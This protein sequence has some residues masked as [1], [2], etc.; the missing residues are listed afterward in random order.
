MALFVTPCLNTTPW[1]TSLPDMISLLYL[2]WKPSCLI[3]LWFTSIVQ[4]PQIE[5]TLVK[6]TS[7]KSVLLTQ[8]QSCGRGQLPVRETRRWNAFICSDPH[9]RIWDSHRL[10][11]SKTDVY[12]RAVIQP[13]LL[14][15][16]PSFM[17]AVRRSKGRPRQALDCP[18]SDWM[19]LTATSVVKEPSF[20]LKNQI[21]WQH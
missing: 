3:S 4:R 14:V 17:R 12:A 2:W 15:S 18:V 13:R 6:L 5:S 1:A 7:S 21:K 8:S 10:T 19:R 16:R 9:Q 20:L 11:Q